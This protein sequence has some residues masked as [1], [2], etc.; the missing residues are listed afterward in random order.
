[1]FY[2]LNYCFRITCCGSTVVIMCFTYTILYMHIMLPVNFYGS[3]NIQRI[4]KPY[5]PIL[6][7]TVTK[8]T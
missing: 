7:N 3:V 2:S 8:L 4:V 1:M 6:V 5:D